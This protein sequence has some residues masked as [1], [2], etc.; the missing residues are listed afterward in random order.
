LIQTGLTPD[1]QA[2]LQD[3]STLACDPD[4]LRGK[5]DRALILLVIGLDLRR[6]ETVGLCVKDVRFQKHGAGLA[7]SI[8][9]RPGKGYSAE[10]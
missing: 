1:Q 10:A 4:S 3:L 5:L 7:V 2:I 9:G 8:T 6:S